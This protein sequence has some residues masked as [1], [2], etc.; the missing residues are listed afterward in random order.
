MTIQVFVS[1][2]RG[3]SPHAAGR[4]VDRL[5]EHFTLFM[6]VDRIRAGVEPLSEEFYTD[7]DW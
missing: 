6:D 2:R 7:A 1:Y 4:L 5:N 3:D